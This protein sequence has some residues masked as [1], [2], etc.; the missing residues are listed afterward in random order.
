M[1]EDACVGLPTMGGVQRWLP[2]ELSEA[3]CLIP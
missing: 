1:N 2:G 3:Q